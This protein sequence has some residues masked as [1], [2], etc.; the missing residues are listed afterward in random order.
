MNR[1]TAIPT[2]SARSL[3][4]YAAV[5][6]QIRKG[7]MTRGRAIDPWFRGHNHARHPLVPGWYRL[8]KR[9][10][11][12]RE[13]DLQDEFQRRAIPLLEG[14]HPESDWEWCFL[15]QHYGLPTRLLDWS[16]SSLVGLFFAI[17]D[18]KGQGG[19][20]RDDAVV[21]MLDPWYLNRWATEVDEVF[22]YDDPRIS[23]YLPKR[24]HADNPPPGRP[25]AL[26][27]LHSNRRLTAQR[28]VFTLHGFET[29]PLEALLADEH[30]PHL[31]RIV[32]PKAS[33]LKVRAEL[34]LTGATDVT[35]FPEMPYLCQDILKGWK[36]T[37]PPVDDRW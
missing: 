36:L 12:Y 35:F 3:A 8:K 19:C 26:M 13:G 17:G 30:K 16:E 1:T 4:D 22:R 5:T 10:A 6:M 23:G 32:V 27:P 33:V 31:A 24:L 28:G 14:R 29:K 9:T 18:W 20:P 15:M 21:W 25:V 37:G 11:R 34:K 7:W 2:Y